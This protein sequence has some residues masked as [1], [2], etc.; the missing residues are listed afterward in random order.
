ML[1]KLSISL[2]NFEILLG[3][4]LA[5]IV[6][7]LIILNVISRAIGQSLYWVDE[8]AIYCMVWMTLLTT[9]AI[10]KKR[11][12]ITVTL[13]LDSLPVNLRKYADIIV[14]LIV[15]IFAVALLGLTINW[16]DIWNFI[17]VGFDVE[18]FQSNTFNFV[19]SENTN[20]LSIKKIWVW[21]PLLFIS[22]SLSIHA[23]VNL[24]ER[25]TA[26]AQYKEGTL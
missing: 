25:F 1:K 14:D 20:T 5:G 16:L 19:Y 23:F 15:F 22:L 9:S 8:L 18:Q 17:K 21:L 2:A 12:A 4:L 13:L 10:L 24:L 11:G 26:K 3:A 7:L 6:T